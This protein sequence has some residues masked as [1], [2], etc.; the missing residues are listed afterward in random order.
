MKIDE[1][2]VK[3]IGQAVILG[4]LLK[5]NRAEYGLNNPEIFE[6]KV[7]FQQEGNGNCFQKK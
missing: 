2:N 7:S 6:V 1:S 4:P 3:N 5:Q